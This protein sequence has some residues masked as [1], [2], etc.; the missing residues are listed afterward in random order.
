MKI[1]YAL[2][3]MITGQ[4]IAVQLIP[5]VKSNMIELPY[6]LAERIMLGTEN[7][8]N[9]VVGRKEGSIVISQIELD[10]LLNLSKEIFLGKDV[11]NFSDEP[12]ITIL[13]FVYFNR[14]QIKLNPKL[15]DFW[16]KF[17]LINDRKISISVFESTDLSTTIEVSLKELIVNTMVR[18][19]IPTNGKFM[20]FGMNCN[21]GLE[22]RH[23]SDAF[24]DL[25]DERDFSSWHLQNLGDTKGLYSHDH[26][27]I[28]ATEHGNKILIDFV[29]SKIYRPRDNLIEFF[30]TKVND[31]FYVIDTIRIPFDIDKEIHCVEFTTEHK[32][33]SLFSSPLFVEEK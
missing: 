29:N 23:L 5:F 12:L 24:E 7:I 14:I 21:L 13:H 18:V 30:L 26:V 9:F 2:Y 3:D 16:K 19:E 22:Y 31:P 20:Q 6:D 27:Q 17:N 33:F 28:I 15:R 32:D 25:S 4:L 8:S 10:P 1:G 11:E